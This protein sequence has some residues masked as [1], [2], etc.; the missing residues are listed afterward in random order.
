MTGEV[1]G[2]LAAFAVI[3]FGVMGKGYG[4]LADRVK[5]LEGKASGH[6]EQLADIGA[7]LKSIEF[8]VNE[9]RGDVRAIRNGK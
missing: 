1:W 6:G 7:R 9:I 3:V 2:V 5:T 4:S 8:T